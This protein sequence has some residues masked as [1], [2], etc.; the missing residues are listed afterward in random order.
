MGEFT[1]DLG[2]W[3][4]FPEEL[5]DEADDEEGSRNGSEE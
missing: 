2:V 5:P 4:W 3:G 1:V